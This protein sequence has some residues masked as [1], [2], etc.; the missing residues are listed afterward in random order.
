MAFTVALSSSMFWA[1][2]SLPASPK[3]SAKRDPSLMMAFSKIFVSI[4]A[5]FFAN[6]CLPL[7]FL[8]MV[9]TM[10]EAFLWCADTS[11]LYWRSP[12]RIAYNGSCR[13]ISTLLIIR[14]IGNNTSWS[15]S[16]LKSKAPMASTT[17][18]NMVC[19]TPR[20][21]S[22][23]MNFRTSK[24]NTNCPSIYWSKKS[25][26]RTTGVNQIVS[27]FRSVDLGHG[28]SFSN[29]TPWMRDLDSVQS[30][31]H[32]L[33]SAALV[34]CGSC[35]TTYFISLSPSVRLSVNNKSQ[36]STLLAMALM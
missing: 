26:W 22:H 25:F 1:M 27:C 29:E 13:M 11:S 23:S 6:F 30:C 4:V 3:P 32:G 10:V 14:S 9:L 8:D 21:A 34:S 5:C 33:A 16:R 36:T 17:T 15:T 24:T 35:P 31:N 7:P 2:I 20:I 28:M 12:S 18:T 19:T